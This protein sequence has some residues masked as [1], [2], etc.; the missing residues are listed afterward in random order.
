M[1]WTVGV[2]D[3][4]LLEFMKKD[5]DEARKIMEHDV[6]LYRQ[7]N[8]EYRWAKDCVKFS[9]VFA[10][11][12]IIAS[13]LRAVEVGLIALILSVAFMIFERRSREK[14]IEKLNQRKVRLK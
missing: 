14:V 8:K 11:L 12:A 4:E 1:K 3:E 6:Q 2:T 9:L 5:P 7:V 13:I 10:T